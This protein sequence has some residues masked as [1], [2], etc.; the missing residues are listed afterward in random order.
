MATQVIH[1]GRRA[2]VTAALIAF[3]IAVSIV[4]LRTQA[5]SIWS[6]SSPV[7][8]Q[9][10]SAPATTVSFANSPHLPAG[11]RVKYG[12]PHHLKHAKP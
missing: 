11:C 12:C 2:R 6:T 9:R 10:L 3:G 4:V 8:P 5:S 1:S 7:Q